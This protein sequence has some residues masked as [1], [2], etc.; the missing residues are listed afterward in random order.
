MNKEASVSPEGTIDK[1]NSI[2]ETV[3]GMDT[4]KEETWNNIAIP[5]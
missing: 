1:S 2:E 5:L 4:I 3:A